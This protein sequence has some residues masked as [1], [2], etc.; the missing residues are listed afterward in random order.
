[1]L[2]R[3]LLAGLAVIACANAQP[4]YSKEVA[5]ILRAKCQGCHRP[6]DIA[7]F[8]LQT[9]EQAS[10]WA[11]DIK[12]VVEARI[13][14]PWKPVPGHG[15]F[16][17]P[18]A[19]TEDDRLTI[20]Q[21]IA[22]GAPA[23]EHTDLPEPLPETG[24]WQLGDPD[25]VVQMAEPFDLKRGG[26][27]YRCFVIDPKLEENKFVSAVQIVPGNRRVVH[28]VILFLDTSGQAEKLDAAENGQ[29][30][31]CYG[32]PGFNIQGSNIAA[33]LDLFSSLG[34]WVPG[35]RTRRLPD[36]VASHLPKNA[37]IVMQVHYYPGA[38][39]GPDQTKIGL[40]WSKTPVARRLMWVPLWDDKF[41]IPPGESNKEVTAEFRIPFFLDAK[42]IQ[43]A[44]H[45]H[46]LGRKIR[47][48]VQRDGD[49]SDLIYINDWDF[50]WQNFYWF[51]D[52]VPV[53][54]GTRLK[55]T[56]HFD[57]T[58]DNPKNPSDP[59]KTVRWGE[60]TED[61]MCI[62]FFGVTFDRENLLPF[63]EKK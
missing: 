33:S 14:P 35:V 19:L 61:E 44:P 11:E 57:N 51:T 31:T 25:H 38:R 37:K 52:Q 47:V 41:Q 18:M 7:P 4:T 6:N 16:Q 36:G 27:V 10:T 21:W 50:N 45:M 23:G 32:G 60:G 13:M 1:M 24:E 26:D 63:Q 54:A 53:P 30:Y 49:P 2:L 28:H 56:C 15:S 17:D 58:K 9:Y 59:L 43:I 62:A 48:E 40:Y 20:L 8:A 42:L 55:L 22:A 12:R 3:F 46:L 39:P 29:G 5:R 34:G